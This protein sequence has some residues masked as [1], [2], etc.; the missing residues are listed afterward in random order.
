MK[1]HFNCGR[2]RPDVVLRNKK[3]GYGVRGK[4]HP[5]YK[6]W[7]SMRSRCKSKQSPDYENY[8]LRG[9]KVCKRWDSFQN[10][11]DDM[12]DTHISGLTIE[13][14]NNDKGYSPS[15]CRW[16][17]MQEQCR[18]RRNSIIISFG[19]RTLTATDWG[20]EL[21]GNDV[22]IHIRLKRGW[23]VERAVSTP[24]GRVG[25]NGTHFIPK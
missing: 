5:L 3:H 23:S 16:A 8:F 12:A 9:I 18:N 1:K 6:I 20:R 21:G 10:F 15:N 4:C 25:S 2:K 24:A 11:F 13:R 22:L 19:G 7:K 14:I 17:T